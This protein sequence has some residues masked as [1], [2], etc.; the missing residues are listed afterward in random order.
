MEQNITARL[1]WRLIL[2]L[3]RRLPDCR[4]MTPTLGESIDRKLSVRER[5][6][7]KLHLFTCEACRV[8]SEQVTFLHKALRMHDRMLGSAVLSSDAKDRI[9]KTLWSSTGLAF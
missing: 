1:K 8:F 4:D 3:A 9:K 2:F 6:I 7:L 5:V